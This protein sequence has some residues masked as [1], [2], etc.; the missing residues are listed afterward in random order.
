MAKVDLHVHS[1]YSEH[2]SEWFL[3]RLGANESYTEPE[4]IYQKAK[5]R[6]MTL[7][8]LTDH[9]RIDGALLL[10]E[11]HPQDVFLGVEATTY[12]P[13]DGCKIHLLVYG[14]TEGEFHEVQKFRPDIY[15][16]RAYLQARNLAHSVAHATFSE[17]NRLSLEKLE[18]LMLLFDTF[19]GINGARNRLNNTG[20]MDA[21]KTLTPERLER[22]QAK[23]RLTPFSETP[24][25]KNF[26]GGSD[27]HA[28]LFIGQTYT[29]SEAETPADFLQSLKNKKTQAC[30]RSNDFRAFAFT[31]YKIAYDFSQSQ[32]KTPGASGWMNLLH[33]LVF[34]AK[35]LGIKNRLKLNSLKWQRPGNNIHLHFKELLESLQQFKDLKAEE[36]LPLVYDRLAGISDEF[37][38]MLFKSFERDLKNGDLTQL[39]MN[40]SASLPGFFLSLPFFSTLKHMHRDR[41]LLNTLAAEYGT[42][43]SR[44]TQKVLWFCDSVEEASKFPAL[45]PPNE[46]FGITEPSRLGFAVIT[47]E[48]AAPELNCAQ[49]LPLPG[50][51]TQPL[52]EVLTLKV[53]SLLKSLEKIEAF[54]PDVIYISSFGPVGWLGL[55]AARL[56]KVKAVGIYQQDLA[57]HFKATVADEGAAE[58][59]DGF[60]RWFFGA[61]DEIRVPS[62]S[63]R[64]LLEAR[65]YASEKLRYVPFGLDTQKY[66]PRQS[67]LPYLQKKYWPAA[68]GPKLLYVRQPGDAKAFAFLCSLIQRTL[69]SHPQ[70][71]LTVVGKK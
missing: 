49:V 51:L 21:L 6:G 42:P 53:P 19:E 10:Q 16:L 4:F 30:G 41:E 45:L 54:D 14:L 1:K 48:A 50:I 34:D 2:P 61:M 9:N 28:G 63:Y 66:A 26:T 47:D 33:S 64:D 13:E 25:I 69:T 32:A 23:H 29:E 37:F 60:C 18:K 36:K 40:I 70:I 5:Q 52:S 7:V 3:Q 65:G 56:M 43:R 68:E 46:R 27:D 62:R 71:Q 20:W 44:R 11:A 12:F 58:L 35:P 31:I 17:N 59:A 38:S 24:W 39:V 22:L 67:R 15:D 57:K 8:T 55:L